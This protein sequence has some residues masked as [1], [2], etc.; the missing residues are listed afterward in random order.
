[1]DAKRLLDAIATAI[2]ADEPSTSTTPAVIPY[3]ESASW[4]VE[5]LIQNNKNL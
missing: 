5:N 2:F 1:M 4:L 3:S